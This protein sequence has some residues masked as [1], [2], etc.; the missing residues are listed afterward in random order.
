[1]TIA[2]T[3]QPSPVVRLLF[4]FDTFNCADRAMSCHN[5]HDR[6]RRNRRGPT[7]GDAL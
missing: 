3:G 5:L 7:T 6:P 4:Y 1:M 2:V